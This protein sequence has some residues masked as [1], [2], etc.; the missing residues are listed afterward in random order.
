MY[1]VNEPKLTSI[2]ETYMHVYTMLGHA[3][4]KQYM[5][6]WATVFVYLLFIINKIK[7]KKNM[8]KTK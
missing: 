1:I 5:P 2:L 3:R 6:I 4:K 8:I 7:I